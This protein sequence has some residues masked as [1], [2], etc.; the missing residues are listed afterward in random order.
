M[1]LSKCRY[2]L[3]CCSICSTVLLF[4]CLCERVTGI[5]FFSQIGIRFVC[6]LLF[7]ILSTP[8]LVSTFMY[9]IVNVHIYKCLHTYIQTTNA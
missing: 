2:L 4:A 3:F 8:V 1:Y 9:V 7:I 5:K 6:Y